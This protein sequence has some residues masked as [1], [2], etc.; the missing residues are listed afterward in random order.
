MCDKNH[1]TI[2]DPCE[3]HLTASNQYT[4]GD[5]E[6]LA[7]YLKERVSI[8]PQI[9][10][11]CGTGLGAVTE[12][13]AD[14]TIFDYK[15]IPKFPVST[16]PG[17]AGRLL[18]GHIDGTPVISMQGRFH[19]FEGYPLWMCTMPVRLMKLLG[20]TTLIL[21]NAAG[22]INPS[23]NVGDIMLIKDHINFVGFAGHNPLRGPNE[24]KF[25][26]RFV[27][28]NDAYSRELLR[29][30]K[31]VAQG[32]GMKGVQEGVYACIGGPSFE[33]V[34][35]LK[36][37]HQLGADAVGMSTVHEVITARHC[38]IKCFALSLITNMC[39]MDYESDEKP[40][41]LEILTVGKER[42]NDV[43]IL[44]KNII[45]RLAKIN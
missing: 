33:T 8:Q 12:L 21:S 13:L 17:H 36:L 41:H 25:G 7:N 5:I 3:H 20:V 26:A 2:T 24:D 44:V 27:A 35:E 28:V 31:A 4:Y 1:N 9:G 38:G 43:K 15:D 22:G 14:P 42:E 40:D 39:V 11:I 34:A 23:F 18:F 29:E 16:V 45:L 30:A 37:M 10:I 19:F 6:E 32:L